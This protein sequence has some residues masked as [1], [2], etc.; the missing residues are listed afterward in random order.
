MNEKNHLPM[1]GVGPVIVIPQIL[2]TAAG[3][4][5]SQLGVLDFVN[6]DMFKIP[7]AIIGII[8]ILLG[9]YMWISANFKVKVDSYI[10]E[11]RLATTGVY[12]IV[13]NPIYS[14]IL[15]ACTGAI[16]LSG[17]LILFLI[18]VICWAYM[19]LMLKKTEEKWLLKL[20]GKEYT[21]YCGRVNRCIPW[22]PKKR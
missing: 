5:L 3:I 21:D 17:D 15:M 9:I 20:Y 7:F 22:F 4:V 2:L 18:P 14:A 6:T 16:L 13:R 12:G 11:N 10:K 8:M 19:T 1:I